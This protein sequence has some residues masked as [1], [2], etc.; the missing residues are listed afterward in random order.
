MR[1]MFR[2]LLLLLAAGLL[3]WAV[4]KTLQERYRPLD[5]EEDDDGSHNGF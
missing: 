5:F 3:L 2:K 1:Q 4:V